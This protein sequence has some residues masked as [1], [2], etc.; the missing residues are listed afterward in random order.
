MREKASNLKKIEADLGYKIFSSS[1]TQLLTLLDISNIFYDMSVLN[2][3][4]TEDDNSLSLLEKLFSDDEK[5]AKFKQTGFNGEIEKQRLSN[6]IQSNG[7]EVIDS[8]F[9]H[10]KDTNRYMSFIYQ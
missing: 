9:R 5:I 4:T 2:H 3:D 10:G 7:G 1:L 8:E 6:K